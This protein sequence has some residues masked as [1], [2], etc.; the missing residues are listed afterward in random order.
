MEERLDIIEQRYEELNKELSSD[1]V[2]QDFTKMTKLNK[3]KAGIEETVT[4]YRELK[5]LISEVDGL[6][7]ML[8]DPEMKDIAEAELTL[9]DKKN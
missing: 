5:K 6:K 7:E 3:E 4:K 9:K 2:L 1:E 8:N